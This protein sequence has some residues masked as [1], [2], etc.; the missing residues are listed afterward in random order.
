MRSLQPLGIPGKRRDL[1]PQECGLALGDGQPG[2][3]LLQIDGLEAKQFDLL[4]DEDVSGRVGIARREPTANR[5]AG[6]PDH[7]HA[8]SQQ[9]QQHPTMR[10]GLL[11][12][13]LDTSPELSP[14]AKDRLDFGGTGIIEAVWSEALFEAFRLH[15]VLSAIRPSRLK[16]D[17][18][19]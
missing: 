4:C 16:Q 19:R 3:R 12:E 18:S 11:E 6:H 1:G 15:P 9:G 13:L 10:A 14:V 8:R 5:E 17:G 2:S 7:E